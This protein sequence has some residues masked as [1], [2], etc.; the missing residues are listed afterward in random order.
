M[1][2]EVSHDDNKC[3]AAGQA[4]DK[5]HLRITMTIDHVDV[6]AAAVVVVVVVVV[7]VIVLPPMTTTVVKQM[8]PSSVVLKNNRLTVSH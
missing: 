4:I 3:L 7:V 1:L 8:M 5:L 6:A 2:E